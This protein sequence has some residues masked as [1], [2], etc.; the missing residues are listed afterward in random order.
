MRGNSQRTGKKR[1]RYTTF[2]VVEL[3]R[4]KKITSRLQLINFAEMQKNE[5]KTVV[6]EFI[7]NR[8]TKIVQEALDLA[9]EF[10]EAPKNWHEYRRAVCRLLQEVYSGQCEVDCNGKWLECGLE[11]LA[12]HEI[13]LSSFCSAI[14]KALSLGRGKYRNVYVYGLSNSGKSF[15]F[16]PLRSIFN[17]F[18]NPATGTF[19]WLGV[20]DVEVVLLN[21]FCWHPPII[22]WADFC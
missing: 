19:A 2:D 8:G 17:T 5:G 9:R 21:D 7:A 10:D 6:A 11:L 4:E 20:E 16:K 12:R 13:E 14:Y 22:V 3:I 15:I 18:T 1:E